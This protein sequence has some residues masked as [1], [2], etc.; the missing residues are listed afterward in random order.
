MQGGD[1]V[2]EVAEHA[3]DLVVAALMQSQAR[4][5]G[6]QQF[7]FGGQGG[8]VL[9]AKVESLS[10]A[11]DAE[12]VD[13]VFGFHKIGF[14]QQAFWLGQATGPEAVVGDDHQPGGVEVQPP[15]NVQF[16]LVRLAQ[17]IQHREVL[18]IG[19]GADAADRF[20]QHKE[21]CGFAC[22]Q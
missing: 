18:R 10:E 8:E 12:G 2:V 4:L 15:G 3:F 17:Q 7:E 14:A 9:E 5:M 13:G 20:V 19:G 16:F 11:V 21:A 6:A 22:L 1:L